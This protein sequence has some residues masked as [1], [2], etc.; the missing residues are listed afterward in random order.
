MRTTST[1]FLDRETFEPCLRPSTPP[2]SMIYRRLDLD[3]LF[4]FAIFL[5]VWLERLVFTVLYLP[6]RG[7]GKKNQVKRMQHWWGPL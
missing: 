2:S 4:F 7:W 5:F 1:T 3:G 6:A